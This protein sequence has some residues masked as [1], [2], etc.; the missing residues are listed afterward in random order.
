MKKNIS[1]PLTTLFVAASIL[2]GFA[3]LTFAEPPIKIGHIRSLTGPIAITNDKMVKGFNLAME[4]FNY[5]IAGRKV[6]IAYLGTSDTESQLELLQYTE[7]REP[8]LQH[9]CY[10]VEDLEGTCAAMADQ[11]VEFFIGPKTHDDGSGRLAFFKD[12]EG[13]VIELVEP[14]VLAMRPGYFGT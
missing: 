7:E 11:G 12:P 13:N 4:M 8:G 2:F 6:E 1:F 3:T 5:Q 14:G 9:F 10:E